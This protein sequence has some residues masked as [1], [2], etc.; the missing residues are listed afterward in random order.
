MSDLPRL[1]N[2]VEFDGPFVKCL[3]CSAKFDEISAP[4]IVSKTFKGPEC[5]F[6]YA[7][8]QDCHLDMVQSFSEESRISL[9]N[10]YTERADIDKRSEELANNDNHLDWLKCCLTCGTEVHHLREY[11][12]AAMGFG[13]DMV[14][15][16]FPRMICGGCEAQ[17]QER[18][19]E[20]TRDQ[21]DRFVRDNFEGPPSE[22]LTPDG[23]IPVLA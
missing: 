3:T 6:E 2:S 15:D 10:F 21:W 7:I 1:F 19:S 20:S 13:T 9:E 4:Y 22:A 18:I 23:R 12:I 14:F 11:S 17:L 5:V 8:C 16:P